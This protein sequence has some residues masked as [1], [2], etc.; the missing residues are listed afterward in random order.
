MLSDTPRRVVPDPTADVG[1]NPVTPTPTSSGRGDCG[2]VGGA[3]PG[4]RTYTDPMV[5]LQLVI[6]IG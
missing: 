4:G 5:R 2:N 6:V 3:A 1:R